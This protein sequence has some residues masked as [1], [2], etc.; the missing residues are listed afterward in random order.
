MKKTVIR[1]VEAATAKAEARPITA[2]VSAGVRTR[3]QANIS[4]KL[5]A[6]ESSAY[7]LSCCELSTNPGKTASKKAAYQPAARRRSPKN[8]QKIATAPTPQATENRRR[9]VNERV[10]RKPARSSAK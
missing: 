3:R 2:Q 7:C 10:T 8:E 9:R 1:W 5:N 6:R 4:A